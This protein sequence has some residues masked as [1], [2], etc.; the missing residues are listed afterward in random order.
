M[1]RPAGRRFRLGRLFLSLNLLGVLPIAAEAPWVSVGP[2]GQSATVRALAVDPINPETVYA[3]LVIGPSVPGGA[4]VFKST[5]AGD[6]WNRVTVGLSDYAVLA[7]AIDPRWPSTLYAGTDGQHGIFKSENG[8]ATWRI[9]NQG[10]PIGSAATSLAI[11]PV[12]TEVVYAAAGGSVYKTTDGGDNWVAVGGGLPPSFTGQIVIDPTS[13]LTLYLAADS[14]FYGGGIF[15]S[16]DGA[17]TWRGLTNGLPGTRTSGVFVA[18]TSPPTIFAGVYDYGTFRSTDGGMTWTQLV[19]DMGPLSLFPLAADPKTPTTIYAN[20]GSGIFRSSDGGVHWTP[21]SLSRPVRSIAVDPNSTST[22]YAGTD[23]TGVFRTRDAGSNWSAVNQGLTGASI[24]AL[25]VDPHE[26]TT[27]YAGG[28]LFLGG[29]FKTTDR[30]VNWIPAND[31][32]A[33]PGVRFP[34]VGAFVF[35]RTSPGAVYVVAGGRVYKSTDGAGSWTL[36][37]RGLT[38]RGSGF[39]EEVTALAIDPA[40]PRTL[41]AGLT[42]HPAVGTISEG[43]MF[44]STD[45]GENWAKVSSPNLA[46]IFSIAVDPHSPAT[47]YTPGYKSRDA[48]ATWRATGAVPIS[49]GPQSV[50]VAPDST[51]YFATGGQVYKSTDAGASWIPLDAIGAHIAPD[52]IDPGVVYV[53]GARGVFRTVDA[54]VTWDP[55]NEGLPD[56]NVTALA[57]DPLDRSNVY[58]GTGSTGLFWRRFSGAAQPH[59]S[60]SSTTLCLIGGRFRLEVSWSARSLGT[61]GAGQAIPLTTNTGAFWFFQPSNIELVIKVLDGRAIDGHFWVFYGALSNVEYTITVTDTQSS[62]EKTYFNPQGRLASVADTSA[63][64]PPR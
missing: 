48:G 39:G 44:K 20:G 26:S 13:R 46:P 9:A 40:A 38:V 24:T 56:T 51:V 52:P 33:L 17:A 28:G 14:E 43:R 11:D 63:F 21:L 23:S 37:S 62:Q 50:A 27:L 58:A 61:S 42:I 29:V 8:G 54:G 2:F 32:I 19:G 22:I 6:T 10:L 35:D 59:C 25:G 18:G 53:G 16:V 57:V 5:N 55:V 12:S 34:A 1:T 30:G 49:I 15:K 45:G 64:S 4:A 31:G 41:Y 3:G 7:L 36:K 47:I 60:Q